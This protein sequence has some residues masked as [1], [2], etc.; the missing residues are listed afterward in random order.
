MDS[1][2]TTQ[3][4]ALEKSINSP[5]RRPIRLL[6]LHE[7]RKRVKSLKRGDFISKINDLT[8][9]LENDRSMNDSRNYTRHNTTMIEPLATRKLSILEEHKRELSVDNSKYLCDIAAAAKQALLPNNPPQNPQKVNKAKLSE[10][11]EKSAKLP[12]E[13]PEPSN[14]KSLY[15]TLKEL[16]TTTNNKPKKTMKIDVSSVNNNTSLLKSPKTSPLKV[17]TPRKSSPTKPSTPYGRNG[18]Q[19]QLNMKFSQE[20]IKVVPQNRNSSPIDIQATKAKYKISLEDAKLEDIDTILT[21]KKPD[22]S[23]SKKLTKDQESSL[24]S[25][26]QR[27]SSST[28]RFL[29]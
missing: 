16:K 1:N 28:L 8:S 17:A 27:S 7:E 25:R 4:A 21:N 19:K 22:S 3:N 5:I 15:S 18:S 29:K 2:T 23:K 9:Y 20:A 13:K 6:N 14:N 10:S 26:L 24:I 12:D 11:E